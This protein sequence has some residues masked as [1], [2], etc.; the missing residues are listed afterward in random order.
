M[1]VKAVMVVMMMLT[2]VLMLVVLF[3]FMLLAHSDLFDALLRLYDA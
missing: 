1:W 3:M 2:L